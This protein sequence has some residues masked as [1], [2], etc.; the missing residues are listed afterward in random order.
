LLFFSNIFVRFVALFP[1]L[2]LLFVLGSTFI[3]LRCQ[4]YRKWKKKKGKTGNPAENFCVR[5]FFWP[6]V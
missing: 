2:Q 4:K 1:H 6:A 3:A 5:M